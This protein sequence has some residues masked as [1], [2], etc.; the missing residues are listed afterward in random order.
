[1]YNTGNINGFADSYKKY[2]NTQELFDN[3][4]FRCIM[5]GSIFEAGLTRRRHSEWALFHTGEYVYN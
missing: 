5:R 4:F 3:W 2:G 1:M